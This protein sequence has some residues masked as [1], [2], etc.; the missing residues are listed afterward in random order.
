MWSWGGRRRGVDMVKG[1]MAT[2]L[3]R[4]RVQKP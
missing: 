2:G 3:V 1:E 4:V